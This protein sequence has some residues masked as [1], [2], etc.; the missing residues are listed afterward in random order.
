MISR[1][2][3]VI[4]AIRRIEATI[5]RLSMAETGRTSSS[6]VSFNTALRQA[7]HSPPPLV[8]GRP[9]IPTHTENPQQDLDHIIRSAAARF[10]LD[11][12]LLHAVIK[13]ESNYNPSAVSRAGA[14]G[15]MQLMPATARALG[16]SN[17]FDPW[18]NVSGGA[19]YLREQLDRFGDI[20]LALAA[21][22][23]GPAAVSRYAIA[24]QSRGG[25]PPFPETRAY[26]S[27]VIRYW[28]EIA[29]DPRP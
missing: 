11:P 9:D 15:L 23:A 6:D 12:A 21:Y 25:I 1:L 8:G 19:R 28:R 13:A 22:N 20:E 10:R 3:Y 29:A 4:A 27:R 5:A 7:C 24:G 2:S 17:I 26:V 14:C 16:V 18:Q